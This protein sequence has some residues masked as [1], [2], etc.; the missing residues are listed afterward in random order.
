MIVD[1][2]SDAKIAAAFGAAGRRRLEERY[3]FTHFQ[4]RFYRAIGWT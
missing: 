3:L 4:A 1:L 2:F